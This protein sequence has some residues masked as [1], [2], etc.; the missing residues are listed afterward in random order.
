M[1]DHC[2]ICGHHLGE[3]DSIA[4]LWSR[5]RCPEPSLHAR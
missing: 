2:P 4:I 3:G 5:H 1:E